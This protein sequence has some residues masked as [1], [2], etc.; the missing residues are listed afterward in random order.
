MGWSDYSLP[1]LEKSWAISTLRSKLVNVFTSLQLQRSK[2][3][4]PLWIFSQ[5]LSWI[6]KQLSNFW[7]NVNASKFY[8]CTMY[9]S[10][11]NYLYEFYKSPTD[12][13]SLQNPLQTHLQLLMSNC[14]E[15]NSIRFVLHSFWC[16]ITLF[17]SL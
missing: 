14:C 4:Q 3:K 17:G 12:R 5:V 16:Y 13:P 7:Y 10:L 2:T 6:L 9:S 8:K 1:Q 11:V 15:L